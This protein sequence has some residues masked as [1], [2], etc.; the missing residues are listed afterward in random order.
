MQFRLDFPQNLVTVR[1]SRS[2]GFLV[3]ADLGGL[4]G[5]RV[6][7]MLGDAPSLL[8]HL[9]SNLKSNHLSKLS[10]TVRPR[11]TACYRDSGLPTLSNLKSRDFQT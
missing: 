10:L 7:L 8:E 5:P 3:F 4:E 1:K 6:P 11:V 2:V 9:E